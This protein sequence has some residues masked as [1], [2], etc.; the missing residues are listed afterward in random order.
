MTFCIYITKI[1]F[2]DL[3]LSAEILRK[4]TMCMRKGLYLP[5]CHRA[6]IIKNEGLKALEKALR[7]YR[8]NLVYGNQKKSKIY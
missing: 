5:C 8:G 4:K 6:C 3:I 7:T 1:T 2:S